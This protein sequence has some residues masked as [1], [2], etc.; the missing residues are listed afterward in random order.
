MHIIK[1][2]ES[3]FDAVKR[4]LETPFES[5]DLRHD[6]V[7][8]V[9]AGHAEP[10]DGVAPAAA[11]TAEESTEEGATAST[12]AKAVEGEAASEEAK[13][14]TKEENAAAKEEEAAAA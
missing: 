14:P 11:V 10:F 6:A 12:E 3:L 7:K 4:V 9:I 2:L 8:T 5:T 13:E 1:D